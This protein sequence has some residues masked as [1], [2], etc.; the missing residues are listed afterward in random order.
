VLRW[1]AWGADCGRGADRW[2]AND[3]VGIVT[4]YEWRRSTRRSRK[5]SERAGPRH[6]I[7]V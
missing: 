1:P 4:L 3:E 5:R 2:I 6:S 7:A